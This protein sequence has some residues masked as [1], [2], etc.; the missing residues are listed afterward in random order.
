MPKLNIIDCKHK[1]MTKTYVFKLSMFNKSFF[2][3]N[4]D[5]FKDLNVIQM[6]INKINA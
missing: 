1:E 5:V 2:A 4:I 6:R 3:G